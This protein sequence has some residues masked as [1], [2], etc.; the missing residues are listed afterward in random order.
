VS[1]CFAQT[2][3]AIPRLHQALPYGIISATGNNIVLTNGVTAGQLIVT[4]SVNNSNT[5]ISIT[6]SDSNTYT[7]LPLTI[8]GTAAWIQMAY[9]TAAHTVS[10]LT[11]HGP[12][13][14]G[15]SGFESSGISSL[16]V[17]DGL[18]STVDATA[19]QSTLASTGSASVSLTTTVNTDV[20][21][22]CGGL[23]NTNGL[24]QG[25]PAPNGSQYAARNDKHDTFQSFVVTGAAGSQTI[26]NLLATV[27]AS[28]YMMFAAAFKPSVTIG[29]ATTALA[30][31]GNGVLCV[32]QLRG[33]GGAGA[34]TWS[35]SAGSWPTGC[36]DASLNSSTGLISC[37]PTA[38]GTFALTFQI[39]DG[40]NTATTPLTLKVGATLAT[41]VVRGT[42]VALLAQ[43][44]QNI[45]VNIPC[46]G[47]MLLLLMHGSD[48][49]GTTGWVPPIDGANDSITVNGVGP[50]SS[51][52][53]GGSGNAGLQAYLFGPFSSF[54]AHSVI[55]KSDTQSAI[56]LKGWLVELGGVQPVI[57]DPVIANA[58]DLNNSGTYVINSSYTTLVPNQLLFQIAAN[59]QAG[60]ITVSPDDITVSPLNQLAFLQ[61]TGINYDNASLG[62]LLVP[63]PSTISTTTTFTHPSGSNELAGLLQFALRPAINQVVVCQ[64]VYAGEKLR[65]RQVF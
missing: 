58:N 14:P 44:A 22:A 36:S 10:S 18:S 9:T 55:F 62:D 16:G 40:T 21:I 43:A 3:G 2:Q 50:V 52:T 32:Q 47:D 24:G 6:D 28:N 59:D 63:T 5:N 8:F 64:T 17:Y 57:D 29:I 39:T 13:V 25:S 30:D 46:P 51:R 1:S 15:G 27:T 20:V 19:S 42:P 56:A 53:F 4:C 45:I 60:A 38:T 65:I 26:G 54:G 35:R 49:H 48:T 23:D 41:P 33:V 12:S 11:V 34:Y 37:T 61:A 31:C 7:L